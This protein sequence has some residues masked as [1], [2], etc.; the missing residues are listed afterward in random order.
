MIIYNGATGGLGRY[1]ANAADDQ[2]IAA[3][4]SRLDDLVGLRR[5]LSRLEPEATVTFVH[6]AAMVSVPACEE[7][8][9]LARRT[10]VEGALDAASAVLDWANERGVAARILFVST[11]H[12]YAEAR[13][14]ALLTEEEATAPRSVYART[15]LEAE[16]ELLLLAETREARLLVA[17]VFGV[18]APVQPPNYLLPGLIRRAMAHELQGI[19]GLDFSRDYLDSRD[20]CANL[21]ALANVEWRRSTIVNVCSGVPTTLRALL[22]IVLSELSPGT[23]GEAVQAATGLAGRPDDI[24]WIVGDPGRFIELTGAQ[25][26]RIP[27]AQTVVDA[28]AEVRRRETI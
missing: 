1:L 15:K 16:K 4:T 27:L 6:L 17:R 7:S 9:E 21:V 19:P 11:G 28:I 8:P 24:P 3:L 20:I 5:E 26:R 12:V 10:N 25:P 14:G 22:Q 2:P 13:R 18:V 23:A